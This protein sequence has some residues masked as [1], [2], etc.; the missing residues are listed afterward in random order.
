MF[1]E[2]F[3]PVFAA[4]CAKWVLQEAFHFSLGF[5]FHK[6]QAQAQEAARKDL[7][8]KMA[9]GEINPLEALFGGMGGGAPGMMEMP[10]GM[11]PPTVSGATDKPEATHGQY[12]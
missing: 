7:E 5:Y 2:I 10:P 11:M 4:L 8:A 6:K 1:F 3:C 9:S 12:L